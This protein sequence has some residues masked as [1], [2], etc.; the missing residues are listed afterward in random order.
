M[1]QFLPKLTYTTLSPLKRPRGFCVALWL[2][3]KAVLARR[4]PVRPLALR[5]G[6]K[7]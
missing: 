1:V 4:V 2:T 6:G 7:C 5:L 3:G